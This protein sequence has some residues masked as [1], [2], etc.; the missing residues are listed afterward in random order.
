MYISR[1]IRYYKIEKQSAIMSLK[2]VSKLNL[3]IALHTSSSVTGSRY[4][5]SSQNARSLD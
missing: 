1:A 4:Y 2:K 5:M 3:R